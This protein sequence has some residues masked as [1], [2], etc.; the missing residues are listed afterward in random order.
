MIK[1]NDE[2]YLVRATAYDGRVRALAIDSTNVVETLRRLQ[3]PEP[4]VTAALGR[5]ATSALLFGALL[6]E[7]DH[8]VTVRVQGGG[9]AG[10]LLASANG[11]GEVRGTVTNPRPG[12][13]QVRAGKLNVSAAVGRRGRITVTRDL[14][15]REPYASTVEL[16]SGEI[17]EDV[18]YY[19][20]RSEQIPSAVGIGV[21]V[22]SDGSVEAAGGYMV[23]LLGGLDEDAAAAIEAEVRTLPH[24]TT[25]LRQGETPEQILGRVFPGGFRLLERRPVRFHCPCSRE[26]AERALVLLGESAL[27][28]LRGPDDDGAELVCDFCKTPYRFSDAEVD[29][30]IARAQD[31]HD[32]R[33]GVRGSRS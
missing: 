29:A 33:P 1:P 15:L 10:T 9:P 22:R 13:E 20:A 24:P 18:A 26:R 17:G 30:L 4:A 16:V 25:M 6:K 5:V 23:Q 21:F 28:E 11:R 7:E 3:D 32:A 12:V 8:L 19:L 2:F 27:R 31:D 14:G